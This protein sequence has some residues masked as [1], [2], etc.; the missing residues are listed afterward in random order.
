MLHLLRNDG[1][2]LHENRDDFGPRFPPV[3]TMVIKTLIF[4][5]GFKDYLSRY[6]C[7]VRYVKSVF[8]HPLIGSEVHPGRTLI[9]MVK[10]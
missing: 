10:L 3:P 4:F 2:T 1:Y 6:S 9:K 8:L 5:N 7:E